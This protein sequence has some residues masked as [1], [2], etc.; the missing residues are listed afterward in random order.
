MNYK[1]RP[2]QAEAVDKIDKFIKHSKKNHG[3][4]VYPTSFGKSLIVANIASKY[5]DKYF[6]NLTTSKELLKQN[7]EKYISYGFEADICSASLNSKNVGKVTFATI[8]TLTKFVDYFKD[9]EVVILFDEAHLA[10]AKGS[11]LDLFLKKLKNY[12][13][14]GITATPFRLS[15][16]MDGTTLKLMNR[17]R[18]CIYKSIE[19]IVQIQEVVSQGY[20]SK[21]LYDIKD[22]DESDLTL[23]TTG[24]EYT[25]S[26]I[27]KFKES[28]D[29]NNQIIRETKKL[30][31]SGRKSILISVPFISDAQEISERLENCEAVYSGMNSKD[32]D[33]IVNDFKNLKTKI[34]VQCSILSVGFDHPQLDA[35]I[36]AKPSN[37]LTFVYQVL[38]RGVR[39]HPEKEDCLIVDFSGNCKKFGEIENITIE[40]S[41]LTKG[42][43]VFNGDT[44][45]SNY[46]L[47]TLNR[48]TK[49]S[50]QAKIDREREALEGDATFYFGK[51]NNKKVS[52]VL[53]ENKSYL[54][55]I[56]DQK[57]FNWY[58]EK[59]KLLKESIEKQLGVFIN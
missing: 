24:T 44:L 16:T 57:D 38:G 41:E 49:Q 29:L 30:I 1:L 55:W 26:S 20:W 15:A 31:N 43:A 59:G 11:Q 3:V 37:S 52:E 32:R 54:T 56:L 9:K 10:S 51:Y 19:D 23:N 13:L 46:P 21:L 50:L 18:D 25:D 27:Q 22:V 53:K 5:P 34:V 36:L 35:I 45:L 39:I 12:K 58:G 42:F 17:D 6:I 33:R 14:V 40:N 8:S 7:Y 48:P 47:N 4:F 2:R 28:N